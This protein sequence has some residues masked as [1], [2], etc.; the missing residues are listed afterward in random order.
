MAKLRKKDRKQEAKV[1]PRIASFEPIQP[2]TPNQKLA[3][4]AMRNYTVSV[5]IGTAG[6][7]KTLLAV[8]EALKALHEHKVQKLILVRPMVSVGESLGYLPGDVGDKVSPYATPLL[9]YI[10]DLMKSKGY[11]KKLMDAGVIELV[12]IALIRG[13]TFDNS[14]II[15]DEAQN[16]TPEEFHAVLTRMGEDSYMIIVGDE[17]QVDLH[18]KQESGLSDFF[19]RAKE[20]QYVSIVEMGVEDIQ[21]NAFLKEVHSWYE[22]D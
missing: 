6:T 10:D 20:S 3:V 21:R 2:R 22:E 18:K 4:V 11:A 14:I 1:Q 5:I 12:P 19:D 13:R 17:M 16:T 9:Y 15:L 7:G 8:S